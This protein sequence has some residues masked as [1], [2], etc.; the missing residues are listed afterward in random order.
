V[1]L[2]RLADTP[3]PPELAELPSIRLGADLASALAGA[4]AELGPR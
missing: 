4:L 2:V 1:F 3:A